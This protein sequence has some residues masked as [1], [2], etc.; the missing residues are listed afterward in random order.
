[1]SSTRQRPQW[2]RI[3]R[4]IITLTHKNLLITFKAP[5]VTICRALVFPIAVTLIFCFLKHIDLTGVDSSHDTSNFGIATSSTPI[6]DLGDAIKSAP[7]Q[8]LVFVRNGISNTTLGPII[9]GVLS[10]PGME[11][12]EGLSVDDPNDLFQLCRQSLT[13]SSNCFAAV[14]FS[15]FNETI[16]EYSIALDESIEDNPGSRY[17]DY[18]TADSLLAKRIMPLQWA[19]D[20]HIGNFS[21]TTARPATV[22]WSGYFG[23]NSINNIPPATPATNAPYCRCWGRISFLFQT[24]S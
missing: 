23:P 14:L 20:S 9:E 24:V 3:Y 8:R 1:M 4:Q 6:R 10:Q 16:V 7:T 12:V 17:G 11:G 5:I 2:R 15:T 19:I 21:A 13:G 22:P 18:H